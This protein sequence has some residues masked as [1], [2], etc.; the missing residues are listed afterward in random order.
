MGQ[1][2]LAV[3]W[4]QDDWI[5]D[6]FVILVHKDANMEHGSYPA[7]QTLKVAAAGWDRLI[8]VPIRNQ[9]SFH[10]AHLCGQWWNVDNE[11]LNLHQESIGSFDSKTG[12]LISLLTRALQ[13]ENN[14][15]LCCCIRQLLERLQCTLLI[16]SRQECRISEQCWLKRDC[17][18]TVLTA[19]S[20]LLEM[21]ARKDYT[22]VGT[23]RHLLACLTFPKCHL[24]LTPLYL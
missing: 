21:K 7:L 17:T 14:F 10:L 22:E 16:W 18:L 9:V 19:S 15:W 1:V 11:N 8:V 6:Q 12:L 23:L 20:K 2:L 13:C 3:L 24:L 5:V 4:N